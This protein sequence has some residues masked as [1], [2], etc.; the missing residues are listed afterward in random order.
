M[1][2]SLQGPVNIGSQGMVT[3]NQLAE[4]AMRIAGKQLRFVIF[5]AL[6][7]CAAETQITG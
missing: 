2:S 4:M 3:I 1:E 6:S 5:L 7:A